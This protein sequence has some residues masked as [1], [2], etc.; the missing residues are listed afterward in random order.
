[1]ASPIR[2]VDVKTLK[3]FLHDG[4]EVALLDA[5]EEV[6]FDGWH[7][8]MASCV[9]L[10]R[11][12][13]L[14]DA[15]VPRRGVRV[16]WC[17][18]GGAEG[19]AETA[20]R[21]MADLGYGDVA[22]LDG[23][24]AAWEA[25]GYT[26]Y[27][28]VHVPSKA[29]AEVIEH[30]AGTPYVTA[31]ELKRMMDDGTDFALF[32]SRTFEEYNDNSIP[33]AICVPGAELVYRFADLV[34]SP[35]TTV[36]VNCGGRTRSI[37]GAQALI[38]AGVPN[39]V[40]SMR[41]GTQGWHLAGF[42]V[43][44]GATNRGPEVSEAGL[45]QAVAAARRIEA[46][47]AIKRIDAAT[48]E[49][50]REEAD[51]HALYVLDVRTR[52]EY[53]AG[54]LAG[55]KHIP[56]GQLVQETDRHL[57][58][59]GARVVLA[60]DTGVRSTMTAFW[61]KQMGWD[62]SII[63]MD[64]TGGALETGPY[65]PR[66]LGAERAGASS[67]TAEDLKS[68]VEAD[69]ATVVDLDWSKAYMRGHIPGAWFMIRSRLATDH[70]K[71]P[72]RGLIVVTAPDEGLA[73][74]AASELAD[75]TAIPVKILKGGTAAWATTG[76]PLE[77]GATNMASAADDIRLRAREQNQ[78]REAAMRRYLAWELELVNQMARDEDQRFQVTCA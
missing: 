27:E 6:P 9:P 62:V 58:I 45:A 72:K 36:V 7:I 3:S 43:L 24:I 56:G 69:G 20:A 39:R 46:R 16:V 48:L 22:V 59:W 12:E 47:F 52:E 35:Q 5:R 1:M 53:E 14:V 78:D 31:E 25:A 44:K 38:S 17:D 75:A 26:L 23:G 60:D 63:A 65:V 21:R 54:H 51:R 13:A 77:S 73:R 42:E 66:T 4:K 8:L 30:E 15:L 28:G 67:I 41:N 32:D 70:R 74:L 33:G 34:P 10:S 68:L 40:V 64:E 29:F 61:L 71:L 2:R 18:D 37:I 50:Y 11:L 57:G 55:V 49:R 19:L 76:Y